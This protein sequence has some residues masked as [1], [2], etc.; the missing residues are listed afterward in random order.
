MPAFLRGDGNRKWK[1]PASF[2]PLCFRFLSLRPLQPALPCPAPL[3]VRGAPRG[4]PALSPGGA[5]AA[6]PPEAPQPPPRPPRPGPAS[7]A[8]TC[9]QGTR[10]GQSNTSRHTGH[11]RRDNGSGRRSGAR[12]GPPAAI[13]RRAARGRPCARA[14]RPAPP[15]ARGVTELMGVARAVGGAQRAGGA[16]IPGPL[17]AGGAPCDARAALGTAVP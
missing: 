7:G 13:F 2:P 16:A 10:T 8:H 1:K 3:P 12:D 15:C 9:P 17:P 4:A 11:V 6:A 5:R 14:A